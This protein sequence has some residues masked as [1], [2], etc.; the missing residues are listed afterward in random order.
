MSPQE[1]FSEGS[2]YSWLCLFHMFNIQ[3]AANST[4]FAVCL[5]CGIWANGLM[6]SMWWNEMSKWQLR[7]L[8]HS[9]T[10]KKLWSGSHTV[11]CLFVCRC[12]CVCSVWVRDEYKAP[13]ALSVCMFVH[14]SMYVWVK[15]IHV[16]TCVQVRV[17]V[18]LCVCVCVGCCSSFW[19]GLCL[20]WPDPRPSSLLCW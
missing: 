15:F 10:L 4:R 2:A 13:A 8:S 12:V 16:C 7:L 1:G 9:L 18:C 6:W 20:S 11:H 5:L 17:C 19:A 3:T 14:L